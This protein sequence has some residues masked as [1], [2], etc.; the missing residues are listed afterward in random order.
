MR[1]A[2]L[3][4]TLHCEGTVLHAG[5]NEDERTS[6]ERAAKEKESQQNEFRSSV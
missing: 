5:L 1:V 3:C 2:P 4:W 6:G